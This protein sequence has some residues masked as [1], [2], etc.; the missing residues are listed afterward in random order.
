MSLWPNTNGVVE[1]VRARLV[2]AMG[3]QAML[4][5]RCESGFVAN[6]GN[7]ITFLGV[8]VLYEQR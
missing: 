6:F 7:D 5:S 2:K 1:A 8:A 4:I 3:H